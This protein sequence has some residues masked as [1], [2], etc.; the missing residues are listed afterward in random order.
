MISLYGSPLLVGACSAR[1]ESYSLFHSVGK[2]LFSKS[3]A[4]ADSIIERCAADGATLMS[5]VQSNYTARLPH[6]DDMEHTS[7]AAHYF[8]MADDIA[9]AQH[10]AAIGD[11]TTQHS[12]PTHTSSGGCNS[13][14]AD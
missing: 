13:R 2:V 3:D 6:D 12:A 5:F 1:D 14:P 4:D 8:S 9:Q 10:N 11:V 7:S